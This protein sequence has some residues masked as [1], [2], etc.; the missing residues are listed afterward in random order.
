MSLGKNF[1]AAICAAQSMSDFFGHGPIDHLFK[2]SEVELWGF[3]SG[4]VKK[5]RR[6][7]EIRNDRD[8]LWSGARRAGGA[9]GLLPRP[10]GD[11]A[12]G[13]DH[14]GVDEEGAGAAAARRG[15]RGAALEQIAQMVVRLITQE[16]ATQVA[17]LR[18][19]YKLLHRRTMPRITPEPSTGLKLGWPYFDEMTGGHTQERP[20]VDGRET[21][22]REDLADALRRSSRLGRRR[23][24][25]G[26]PGRGPH[27][28]LDGDGPVVDPAAP[29]VAS[30]EGEDERGQEER[31]VEL[32]AEY[33]QEGPEDA[34]GLQGPVLG[35]GRQPDRDRR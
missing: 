3:V 15:G 5:L 1:I 7:A 9:S 14:Q 31:H 13:G 23:N 34:E 19:A 25:P 35:G 29:G 6:A 26:E 2:G 24:G 22:H 33:V 17:D 30:H 20:G 8:P 10:D 16:Q 27:V 11:P 4:F 12:P 28:R 18:Q 32:R 21:R